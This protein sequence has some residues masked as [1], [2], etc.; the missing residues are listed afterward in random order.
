M[1]PLG[2]VWLWYFLYGFR[3]FRRSNSYDLH[4][5]CKSEKMGNLSKSFYQYVHSHFD[6]FYCITNKNYLLLSSVA[7][8]LGL[9]QIIVQKP[10]EFIVSSRFSLTLTPT[11]VKIA[12]TLGEDMNIE[13]G[14][15][16]STSPPSWELKSARVESC[17]NASKIS[18]S[19]INLPCHWT[20]N[21]NEIL[22]IQKFLY[23]LSLIERA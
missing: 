22:L 4:T 16:F 12:I 23:E 13:V 21:K 9:K 15:W 7:H 8:K 18:N 3:I 17:I 11:N 20:L 19:I 10:H 6:K 14:R 5:N 1:K 2:G